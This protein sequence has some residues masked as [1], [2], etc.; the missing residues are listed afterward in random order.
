VA[1]DEVGRVVAAEPPVD[2]QPT[3]CIA[4]GGDANAHT[5]PGTA[6]RVIVQIEGYAACRDGQAI[7]VTPQVALKRGIGRE[8]A[9]AAGAGRA[10]SPRSAWIGRHAP[11]VSKVSAAL[12]FS[13]G[14]TLRS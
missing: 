8:L 1:A 7:T 10:R 9:S 3:A 14:T 12:N 6:E 13:S 2:A 5:C 4:A 11:A